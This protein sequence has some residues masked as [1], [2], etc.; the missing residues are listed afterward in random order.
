MSLTE[1]DTKLP[2]VSCGN[3]TATELNASD[4]SAVCLG[5]FRHMCRWRIILRVRVLLEGPFIGLA[6]THT[7]KPSVWHFTTAWH[8]RVHFSNAWTGVADEQ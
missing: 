5:F 1:V 7:H 6:H 8:Y 4:M 3:T 2:V